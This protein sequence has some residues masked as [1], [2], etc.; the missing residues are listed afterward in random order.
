MIHASLRNVAR[1]ILTSGLHSMG[2]SR[3]LL[4][5]I[6]LRIM[7]K[8]PIRLRELDIMPV[9]FELF[10]IRLVPDISGLDSCLLRYCHAII[11][12]MIRYSNVSTI[13]HF[14]TGAQSQGDFVLPRELK[15][16]RGRRAVFHGL[17]R[18]LDGRWNEGMGRISH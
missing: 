9:P 14:L 10:P 7:S 18:P 17:S 13:P 3:K 4:I 11:S 12:A 5:G 1:V 6:C 8:N 16:Y 15:A 2:R